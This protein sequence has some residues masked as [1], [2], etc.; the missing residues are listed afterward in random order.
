[1]NRRRRAVR[2]VGDRNITSIEAFHEAVFFSIKMVS[3]TH[4]EGEANETVVAYRSWVRAKHPLSVCDCG[5]KFAP[6]LADR[7]CGCSVFQVDGWRAVMQEEFAAAERQ[8]AASKSSANDGIVLVVSRRGKVLRRGVGIP[9]WKTIRD[10]V[11]PPLK[12]KEN[13]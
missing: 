8:G 10:D 1:M 6:P 7:G 3:K 11:D 12:K 2:A 13:K 9:V 4:A 5:T